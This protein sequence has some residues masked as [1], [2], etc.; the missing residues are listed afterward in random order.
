MGHVDLNI[1]LNTQTKAVNNSNNNSSNNSIS[2]SISNNNNSSSNNITPTNINLLII[3]TTTTTLKVCFVTPSPTLPLLLFLQ[4]IILLVFL[5]FFK[6]HGGGFKLK[7]LLMLGVIVFIFY[8]IYKQC[9]SAAIPPGAGYVLFTSSLSPI[10][11]PLSSEIEVHSTSLTTSLSL[12]FSPYLSFATDQ[13]QDDGEEDQV[14]IPL[15]LALTRILLSPPSL[16]SFSSLLFSSPLP[17][18]V[19]FDVVQLLWWVLCA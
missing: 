3:Q 13:D 8:N 9:A 2:I 12:F 11:S 19:F 14:A 10:L 6:D 18:L 17:P 16:S 4:L 5:L 15:V 7:S 1:P